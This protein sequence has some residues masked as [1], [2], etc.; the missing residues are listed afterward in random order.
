[1]NEVLQK[2][3][4]SQEDID[5]LEN[6]FQGISFN[7]QRRD[8]LSN[9]E[10]IQV[11]A[12]P[13][14]GKTT[15]VVAKLALMLSKWQERYKGICVLSHTNVAREEIEFRIGKTEYGEKVFSYPHFVGTIHSFLNTYIS[16]PWLRANG[17]AVNLI[18]T[19][20]VLNQRIRY[21][22][23]KYS[24]LWW[25]YLA[26]RIEHQK[27]MFESCSYEPVKPRNLK[28][29]S[30]SKT[31]RAVMDCIQKS[32]QAG[33]YTFGEML[34]VCKYVLDTNPAICS[35]ICRRFPVVF[36]DESQDT[37]Q[38]L[39]E[40]LHQIFK[41]SASSMQIFGDDNQAIYDD[42]NDNSSSFSF[43]LTTLTLSESQRFGSSIAKLASPLAVKNPSEM[44]GANAQYE[45]LGNKHTIFL[46]D[47]EKPSEVI[48]AFAQLVLKCFDDDELRNP[49]LGCHV[50][51]MIHKQNNSPNK[52]Y[53]L[54]D[55]WNGYDQ[56][57]SHLQDRFDRLSY[58]F[59]KAHTKFKSTRFSGDRIEWISKGLLFYL[60]SYE[61]IVLP[62]KN[63]AFKALLETVPSDYKQSFRIDVLSLSK[64][65][66]HSKDEWTNIVDESRKILSKYFGIVYLNNPT[67]FDWNPSLQK[68]KQIDEA[69]NNTYEYVCSTSH[70]SVDLIFGSIHSV[71]GCTHLATL[72]VE[73]FNHA[74]NIK[75][76]YKYLAGEKIPKQMSDIQRKRLNCHYVALTRAKGLICLAL[77]KEFLQADDVKKLEDWGWSIC[78][79]T[80]I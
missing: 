45:R 51:G 28:V 44:I 52:P 63:D 24:R 56:Q 43:D 67:F 49:H 7:K 29:K 10:S 23:E 31:Y 17:R 59:E 46:F 16:I 70:R 26:T 68:A 37:N 8:I 76:I 4:I 55:Y 78:D 19:E 5:S 36:I 15:L 1:M 30:E 73:T 65:P 13:G 69:S 12:Y 48:D 41:D 50:V 42:V 35:A 11:Q 21:L 6:L 22:Q 9:F 34:K 18:D 2:I 20:I 80:S 25:G 62:R 66:L 27:E 64:L 32:Q 53:S 54:A 77:P 75:S 71:K 47:K 39:W 79:I 58:F 57:K 72:V 33:N 61:G 40:I 74:H 14:S 3:S 38:E 60:R